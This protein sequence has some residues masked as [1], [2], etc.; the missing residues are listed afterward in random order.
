MTG[1]RHLRFYFTL[2]FF[3]IFIKANSSWI[4]FSAFEFNILSFWFIN[5]SY[6]LKIWVYAFN[7]RVTSS[8]LLWLFKG[9]SKLV[10]Q[11]SI[12]IIESSTAFM[13][14]TNMMS[15]WLIHIIPT[16]S[17]S[18]WSLCLSKKCFNLVHVQLWFCILWSPL[19]FINFY[20]WIVF[21]F[22]KTSQLLC[23]FMFSRSKCGLSS[24]A[25]IPFTINQQMCQ[26]MILNL[27][28]IWLKI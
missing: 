3:K 28:L 21:N 16:S 17:S 23:Y 7:V 19:T 11:F 25:L 8:S 24:K 2:N 26:R 18:Y 6:H 15:I 20:F 12:S 22:F 5:I 27:I 1:S 9:L 13:N 4:V 14:L 10:F